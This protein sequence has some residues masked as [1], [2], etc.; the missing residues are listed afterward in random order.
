MSQLKKTN[1]LSE[2]KEIII[3]CSGNHMKLPVRRQDRLNVNA[4]CFQGLISDTKGVLN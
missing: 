2:F 4:P 3:V 1:R